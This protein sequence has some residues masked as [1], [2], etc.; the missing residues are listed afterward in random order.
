MATDKVQ[1][2]YFE[3][4]GIRYMSNTTGYVVDLLCE[5][6][7]SGLV[8]QEYKDNGSNSIGTIGYTAGV[9]TVNYSSNP[10]NGE[11]ASIY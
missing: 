6:E 10:D 5:G 2:I 3:D 11:L 8:H 7:I 4:T 1:G 9:T